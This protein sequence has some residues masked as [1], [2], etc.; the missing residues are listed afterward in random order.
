MSLPDRTERNPPPTDFLSSAL[1]SVILPPFTLL[2][3]RRLLRQRS[4]KQRDKP[5]AETQMNLC[6]LARVSP[7]Q[8][9][10]CEDQPLTCDCLRQGWLAGWLDRWMRMLLQDKPC[11]ISLRPSAHYF[12]LYVHPSSP[13]CFLQLGLDSCSQFSAV[14][15]I[16]W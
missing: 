7:T 1:F 5:M 6:L 15:M 11:R 9:T 8:G 4:Q 3:L 14:L 10:V 13:C 16:E 12:P 2:C